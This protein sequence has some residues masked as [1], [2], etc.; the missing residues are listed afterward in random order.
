[1]G[2]LDPQARDAIAERVEPFGK[3]LRNG[4]SDDTEALDFL[5][6]AGR[7]ASRSTPVV[8]STIAP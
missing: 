6:V 4:I 1:M 3:R 8:S 2:F 7:G 5:S